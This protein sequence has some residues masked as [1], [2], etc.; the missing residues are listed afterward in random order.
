RAAGYLWYFPR[1]PTEIN[2]GLGFQMNEQPMHLVEDLREDL[3]NRPEFEGAVVEDKLGAALPTRRPYD[4]A[5]A[6][7]F[8]AVGDAAG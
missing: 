8:I 2:V 3:R 6:P 1:T 5:V 4:S 7:G